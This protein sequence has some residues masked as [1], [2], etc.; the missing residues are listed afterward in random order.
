MKIN[1]GSYAPLSTIDDYGYSSVVIFFRGCELNCWYCHNKHLRNGEDY[2]DTKVVKEIIKASSMLVS[3]ATFSGGEP[4]LQVEAL[5]ELIDYTHSLGLDVCLYTSGNNPNELKQVVDRVD[6]CYV[7]FKLEDAMID[8]DDNTYLRNVVRS[9]TILED[10]GVEVMVTCVVF[11]IKPETIEAIEDIQSF[12]GS[13]PL[14][15]IQGISSCTAPLKLVEMKAAFQHCY[16][17]TREDG[18]VQNV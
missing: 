6:R 1:Y 17:R 2:L 10:A 18:V 5:S 8:V 9:L 11:D 14:T 4:L 12:I 7:D 16:I 3:S 15:V 13:L